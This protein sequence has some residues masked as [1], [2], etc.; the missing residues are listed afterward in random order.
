MKAQIRA[1]TDLLLDTMFPGDPSCV[2]CGRILDP[3]V[4]SSLCDA[5]IRWARRPFVRASYLCPVCGRPAPA[6]GRCSECADRPR[7]FGHVAPAALYKEPIRTLIVGLKYGRRPDL[8]RPLGHL[9]HQALEHSAYDI[10]V[11]VPLHASHLS[12]RQYN[13]AA[14]LAVEIARLSGLEPVHA[15]V[16]HAQPPSQASLD[17]AQ[18]L[19][20]LNR[21][22]RPNPRAANL[23]LNARALLVDDVF[24]TGATAYACASILLEMG[25]RSVDVVVAAAGIP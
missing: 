8:A 21:V 25:A 7:S 16:K 14:L 3:A 12:T 18:R 11:P 9:M 24:T 22:F 15:L 13:Q 4:R 10:A 23:V 20:A 19:I 2:V 1:L 6:P 17:R 5:C